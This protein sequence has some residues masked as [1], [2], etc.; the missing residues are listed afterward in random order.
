M[1]TTADV[2]NESR[3]KG[4]LEDQ[5]LPM[6]RQFAICDLFVLHLCGVPKAA[7]CRWGG[8]VAIKPVLWLALPCVRAGLGLQDPFVYIGS[9]Q[10]TGGWYFWK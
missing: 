10:A 4:S 5:V 1:L 2:G 6:S 3:A 8:A 7:K 9:S